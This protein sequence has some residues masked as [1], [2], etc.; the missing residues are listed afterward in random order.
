MGPSAGPPPGPTR[1]MAPMR[2][3]DRKSKAVGDQGPARAAAHAPYA[4]MRLS[5]RKSKA[6]QYQALA[7]APRPDRRMATMCEWA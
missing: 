7:Q 5:E 1:R 2:L 4:P 6:V 3:S